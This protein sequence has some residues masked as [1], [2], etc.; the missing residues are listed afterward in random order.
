MRTCLRATDLGFRGSLGIRFRDSR[1][2][3]AA[4][5]TLVGRAVL[6]PLI[7]FKSFVDQGA[8]LPPP[9][10]VAWEGTVTEAITKGNRTVYTVRI[11]V[12]ELN[13]DSDA[14]DDE[15]QRSG[16]EDFTVSVQKL[17]DLLVLREGED[18]ASVTDEQSGAGKGRKRKVGAPQTKVAKGAKSKL[19][20][21]NRGE[22]QR[23]LQQ[24]PRP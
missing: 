10:G 22:S 20:S 23:H 2:V 12:N 11:V 4:M 9:N 15:E 5:T 6:V 16:V 8:S 3:G 19:L 17:R 13:D 18:R 7:Y 24:P 1:R 21:F 14:S